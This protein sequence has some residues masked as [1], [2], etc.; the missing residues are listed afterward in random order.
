MLQLLGKKIDDKRLQ[1]AI[2]MLG[3]DLKEMKGN[4]IL[5]EVFPN[6]PDLLSE[7]GMARALSSFLGMK[8]GLRKYIVKPSPYRFTCGGNVKKI[9][10]YC[11]GAVIKGLHFTHA[12]I[13]SVMQLQEKLH[14]THGR[15]RKKVSMGIYDLDKIH[16]PLQLT[17][18]KRD[19]RMVPLDYNNDMSLA[20]I[21]KVHPKGKEFADLVEGYDVFPVWMD[22]H[23]EIIGFPPIINGEHAKVTEKTRN[24]FIDVTGHDQVAVEQALHILVAAFADL[25]GTIF[26]VNEYPKMQ[27]WK[28]TVDFGKAQ[29]L[30]GLSFNKQE[31]KKLL[32]KMG[33]GIEGNKVLVPAYRTNILHPHDVIEDIAIAYGFD[34]LEGTLPH[35]ATIGGE[36]HLHVFKHKL[37]DILVGLGLQEVSTFHLLSKE[38][39]VQGKGIYKA[40]TNP[41]SSD[42]SCLRNNLLISFLKVL[43]SNKHH[44][45]PQKIFELGRVFQEQEEERVC[46]MSSHVAANFTE[47]KQVVLA[48][49]QALQLEGKF[50][51]KEHGNFISGRCAA[52]LVQGKEIGVLGEMHPAT[53]QAFGLEMPV[54]C[55][56]FD[57][58]Q[59]Y[60]LVRKS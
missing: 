53:L 36:N 59:L 42:F 34:K 51:E 13:A 31:I 1:H 38:D 14:V 35:V 18:V 60:R 33:Y 3:T 9:L 24:I 58:Q 2:S 50:V 32:G 41:F 8:T 28:I 20:D 25:G 16:F 5:V 12:S 56:E 57:T 23:K 49:L 10:P 27:P 30:I 40:I 29:C 55:F 37:A 7:E 46:F 26:K 19:A 45:Y 52:L 48:L 6:R 15:N 11:V 17:T 4:E 54:C 39:V 44:E 43:E 47:V 22:K 21:L